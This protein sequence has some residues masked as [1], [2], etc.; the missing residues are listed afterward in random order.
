MEALLL[1]PCSPVLLG[2]WLCARG[3]QNQL[4]CRLDM[5]SNLKAETVVYALLVIPIKTF[6]HKFELPATTTWLC[7]HV[8][9]YLLPTC[10]HNIEYTKE[11]QE[12]KILLTICQR[13][14][15]KQYIGK[16][17]GIPKSCTFCI[18]CFNF[19]CSGYL[20]QKHSILLWGRH[21]EPT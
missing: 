14:D 12:K 1:K 16:L 18:A 5:N 19:A 21:I 11:K 6:L 20:L 10:K 4:H 17:G 15:P 2:P 9:C 3:L 7:K 8:F 13:M